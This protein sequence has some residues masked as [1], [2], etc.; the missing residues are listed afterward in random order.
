[1]RQSDLFI[2]A[3]MLETFSAASI[4]AL[5]SGTPV[6]ATRCGG[7]EEFISA[8]VGR[9]VPP[10]DSRALFF[11]LDEMLNN[12]TSFNPARLAQYAA[13]RFSYQRVGAQFDS[14]YAEL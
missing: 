6:L 3:S 5:A 1:M 9:L 8:E 13:E 11:A 10:G 2:L 4:E 14:I 12:L 7:P